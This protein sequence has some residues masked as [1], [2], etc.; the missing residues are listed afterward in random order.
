M[1]PWTK[2]ITAANFQD[3]YSY[4][5]NPQGRDNAL[6]WENAYSTYTFYVDFTTP[7]AKV[8]APANNG[9]AGLG[10]VQIEG[11]AEDRF[12]NLVNQAEAANPLCDM[13]D[14]LVTP[15]VGRNKQ[16][17]LAVSSVT[18]AIGEI[19]GAATN[20]WDG[21]AFA[22]PT[23]VWSTATF[24]GESSGT[25][26][27]P[28]GASKL[29]SPRQ[30]NVSSRVNRDR[31]G[32]VQNGVSITT[33]SFIFDTTPPES[34]ATFPTGTTGQV[35]TI[36]GTALDTAPGE[37]D[38]ILLSI[39][40]QTG[41][42]ANKYW[43]GSLWAND[44]VWLASGVVGAVISGSTRSWSYDSSTVNYE[45]LATFEVR[46][47][48]RDKGGNVKSA[49]AQADISFTLETPAPVLFLEQAPAAAAPPGVHYQ[50]AAPQVSVIKGTGF[51]LRQAGGVR[52]QIKRLTPPTSWYAN[53]PPAW[54]ND[55]A[56]YTAVNVT[57]TASPMT[58]TATLGQNPYSVGSASYTLTATG[59]NSAN[60]PS[61]PLS[62]TYIV[63]DINPIGAYTAPAAAACPGSPGFDA[64][65]GALP[66]LAGTAVDPNNADPQGASVTQLR[67]RIR[68]KVPATAGE[69]YWNGSAWAALGSDMV[70]RATP[71]V[72]SFIWSTATLAQG[73]MRDGADYTLYLW[74]QD[75]AGNKET[76]EDDMVKL[77]FVYDTRKPTAYLLHP[78][79]GEVYLDLNTITGTAD[80]PL[81]L[82]GN[83]K[84][85]GVTQVQVKIAYPETNT[86]FSAGGLFN[87]ICS[88]PA[89]NLSAAGTDNW[90]YTHGD[91]TSR[92]T[93]GAT[94]VITV[95]AADGAA[96]QQDTYA[97]PASSRTIKVD[98]APPTAG[99]TLPSGTGQNAYRPAVLNGG[100]AIAGTALDGEKN[101]YPS[102]D[103]LE[104]VQL[105]LWY[106][107]GP[108]SYY[109]IAAS[110]SNGTK[111]SSTTAE[112]FEWG[113]VTVFSTASWTGLFTGVGGA[114]GYGDWISD[115]HYRAAARARDRARTSTGTV[116][117][118]VSNYGA[119]GVDI[120]DFVVDGT[121]PSSDVTRPAANSFI[122]NL[123]VISGT[124][125][126]DLAQYSTYYL[127]VTTKAGTS[128]PAYWGGTGWTM[129]P[130]PLPVKLTGSTGTLLWEYPGGITGHSAP[131]VVEA[132]GTQYGLCFQAKDKA[133]NLEAGTTVYVTKDVIGPQVVIST[134]GGVHYAKSQQTLPTLS[135]TSFDTPAG[136][137]R[138]KLR[139]TQKQPGSAGTA[140]LGGTRAGRWRA[141][142]GMS[143]IRRTTG[144]STGL[145]EAP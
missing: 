120:V 30:Y 72:G 114:Q 53:S 135:G 35:N 136:V 12:C 143:S 105:L 37:L 11:T 6:N 110:T 101:L 122:Q 129:T 46:A 76:V 71:T 131:T 23:P 81:G 70:V 63:D 128:P 85:A 57:T 22:S 132:E 119:P 84:Y 50:R 29:T 77:S 92:L 42:N 121:P 44:E 95:F 89:A 138:V 62:R 48:A 65:L 117:G 98:L 102:A 1:D 54:S 93:S 16:S 5:V 112:A 111:F 2:A 28:F 118:N 56:T 99:F 31:A 127:F 108:T 24:V 83:N 64:C 86:C 139:L 91:L 14:D 25:W 82:N 141:L 88:N 106:V 142:A 19:I 124:S 27:W 133:G 87:V 69:D 13:E 4:D 103:A 39:F 59:Y 51:N 115:K 75:K 15:S 79:S 61:S 10:L 32:N 130:V 94:Y 144:P 47:K 96:N 38:V 8:S 20:Y 113:R 18:V 36:T 107:L 9:F 74:G 140:R 3:G 90:L 7:I 97:S 17:G 126:S 68:D 145:R 34:F 40:A 109:Y 67:L 134:P 52:L 104:N 73:G 45:N 137:G 116:V 100:S 21:A 55:S 66:E 80:D 49:P 43:S 123:A 58:W 41:A 33:N 125:N 78:S 26:T 60:E